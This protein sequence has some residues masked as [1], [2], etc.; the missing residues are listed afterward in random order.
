M[1]KNVSFDAPWG[2]LLKVVTGISILV[3]VS[4]PVLGMV[5]GPTRGFFMYLL[6]IVMPL[7]TLIISAFFAIRGYVLTPDYLH[8]LR[9]GWITKLDLSGLLSAAADPKAMSGSIRTFGNGGLFS[10]TGKF[11]NKKLGSYRA[12]ATDPGRAVVLKFDSRVIVVTP[13]NPGK[14]VASIREMKQGTG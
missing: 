7:A 1:D 11:R 13:D 10:I 3:S 5:K 2:I 8:I 12:F 9:P 4:I 6:V 14:F